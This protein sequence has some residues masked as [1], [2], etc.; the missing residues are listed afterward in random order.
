MTHKQIVAP[1]VGAWIETCVFCK[2]TVLFIVAPHVGAWIETSYS[3]LFDLIKDVAPHVGAWI[4]TK[5][6]DDVLP[7]KKSHPMW[8]RGLKPLRLR[9]L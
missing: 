9:H 1:H 7:I 3:D 8:V 5:T 6:P 2:S 4:E